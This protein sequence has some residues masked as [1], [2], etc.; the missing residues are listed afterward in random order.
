MWRNKTAD[1]IDFCLAKASTTVSMLTGEPQTHTVIPLCTTWRAGL[2]KLVGS[3]ACDEN[4]LQW[5]AEA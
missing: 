1:V 5:N 3:L 2:I 4:S